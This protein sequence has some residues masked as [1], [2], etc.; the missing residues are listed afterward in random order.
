MS[1]LIKNFSL[2]YKHL[3]FLVLFVPFSVVLG[4]GV[5]NTFLVLSII[6]FFL[7][8]NNKYKIFTQKFDNFTKVLLLFYLYLLIISLF[9]NNEPDIYKYS[10]LKSLFF[11]K[12]LFFF[13]IIKECLKNNIHFFQQSFKY[14]LPIFLLI[15]LDA[16]FQFFTGYN[17]VGIELETSRVSGFFGDEWILGTF[18]FH[19]VP[20]ILVSILYEIKNLKYKDISIILISILSLFAIYISGE[21]TIFFTSVIYFLSIMFFIYIKKLYIF[22]IFILILISFVLIYSSK[23]IFNSFNF[24]TENDEKIHSTFDVY[25]D[26]YTTSYN[27]FLEKKFFGQGLQTFKK[28]C[29]NKKYISGRFGCSSHPHNYYFQ[30]LSEN[31]IVGFI[32]FCSLILFLLKDAFFLFI[33]WIRS[34]ADINNLALVILSINILLS[35]IPFFPTGNF[36]SSVTGIFLFFKISIFY[37][38]K[39]HFK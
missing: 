23:R 20:F 6:F 9:N 17:L 7:I 14:F 31:G 28:K 33:K 2:N 27:M 13:L 15:I 37:G 35:F 29:N 22:L 10:L 39:N 26:L 38:L 30:V 12:F 32:I 25:K 1:S 11:F 18:V 3:T 36:Y 5:A 8:D 34:Q 24:M 4:T 16:I 19:L 21:R